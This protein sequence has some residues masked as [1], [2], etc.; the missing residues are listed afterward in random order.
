MG[1]KR[2]N[3][4]RGG[5]CRNALEHSWWKVPEGSGKYRKLVELSGWSVPEGP[6]KCRKIPERSRRC[7]NFPLEMEVSD[8]SPEEDEGEVA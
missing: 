5:R 1:G 8:P 3:M 7:W 4:E 6:G 2:K